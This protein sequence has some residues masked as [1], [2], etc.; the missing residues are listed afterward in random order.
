MVP[1]TAEPRSCPEACDEVWP[2][3]VARSWLARPPRLGAPPEREAKRLASPDSPA[4]PP[5][6]AADVLDAGAP[7][8]PSNVCPELRPEPRSA[9]RPPSAAATEATVTD[10]LVT[11]LSLLSLSPPS[12]L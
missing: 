11:P 6:V 10:R 5:N 12:P 2:P 8:Q 9:L 4:P 7:P 3:V 1:Q